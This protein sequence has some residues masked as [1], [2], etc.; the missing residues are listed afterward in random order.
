MSTRHAKATH[1]TSGT[2]KT[3]MPTNGRYDRDC[4]KRMSAAHEIISNKPAMNTYCATS[5]TSSVNL[6]LD[7]SSAVP[8]AVHEPLQASRTASVVPAHPSNPTIF[9][10]MCEPNHAIAE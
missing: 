7:S 1:T 3:R 5:A 8:P 9:V 6:N 10:L 2:A 4:V